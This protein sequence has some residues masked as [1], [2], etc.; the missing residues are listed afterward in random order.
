MIYR[1]SC[2]CRAIGFDYGTELAP[3]SWSVRACQCTFCRAH[4]A[5]STSDPRGTLEFRVE[6]AGK[7]ERYRFA[8]RT[9]DFLLCRGCG[10]YIGAVLAAPAGRFGIINLNTLADRLSVPTAQP[11]NYDAEDETA[12]IARRVSRWTPIVAGL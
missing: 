7:L 1:G 8:R 4:G 2:H 11:A 9:A 3:E 12:R 6:A 10:V 5:L